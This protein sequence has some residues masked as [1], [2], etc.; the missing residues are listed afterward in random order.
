MYVHRTPS[1]VRLAAQVD[2]ISADRWSGPTANYTRYG[3]RRGV[4]TARLLGDPVLEPHPESVVASVAGKTVAAKRFRPRARPVSM[5]VPLRGRKG[6][7]QVTFT[8][9]PTAVPDQVLRNGDTRTL[10]VRFLGFAYR[11]G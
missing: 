3:C 4:L 7:C 1:P 5:L 2:G 10:G 8:V 9:S 11:P 6:L